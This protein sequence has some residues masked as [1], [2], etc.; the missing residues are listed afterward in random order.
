EVSNR[1]RDQFTEHGLRLTGLSPDGNLVEIIEY[2]QHPWFIGCQFHPELK[3]RPNRPHPLF[4][5]FIGAALARRLR[6][7][8]AAKPMVQAST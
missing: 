1:F 4:A 5:G 6:E 2:P 3:S 8:Q 7:P